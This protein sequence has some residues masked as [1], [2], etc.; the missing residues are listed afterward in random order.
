MKHVVIREASVCS[1]PSVHV[2]YKIDVLTKDNHWMLSRRYSQFHS[3]HQKLVKHYGVPRDLLPPKRLSG[4]LSQ[5]LM[6]QRKQLLERYLQKLI[7]S[8]LDV[9]QS[10][11]LMDFLSV[12]D[13]DIIDVTTELTRQLY[14]HGICNHSN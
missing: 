9:S 14:F 6:D 11:E 13:H 8:N 7:N 1:D 10:A 3:L 2:V 12:P 5:Q 4:N